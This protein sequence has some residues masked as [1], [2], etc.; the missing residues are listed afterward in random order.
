MAGAM[1][2]QPNEDAAPELTPVVIE[3]VPA[4]IIGV[5]LATAVFLV[6]VGI[7]VQFSAFILHHDNL[8]G[9]VREFDLDL[10]NNTPSWFSTVLI[11][12]CA[13][14]LSVIAKAKWDRHDPHAKSWFALTAIF[15][16]L[17][18]D[19]AASWHE[20]FNDC[21][22]RLLSSS[23][24]SPRPWVVPA[25]LVVGLFVLLMARF[26]LHLPL[27]TRRRFLTA[28]A[29]YVVGCVG[30]EIIGGKYLASVGHLDFTYHLTVAC[31]EGLEMLGMVLFQRA[32]LLYLADYSGGFTVRLRG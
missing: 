2:L 8:L 11:L 20:T 32:L 15:V 17:S 23:G 30:M 10:E 27:K 1:P 4:K 3:V 13:M 31:E 5:L 14:S 19:E 18:L 16:L 29:V 7:A 22:K 24:L 12:S 9:L 26:L 21:L 25:L 28:G 6:A